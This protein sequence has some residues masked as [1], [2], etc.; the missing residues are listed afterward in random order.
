MFFYNMRLK[1]FQGTS[2]KAVL[3]PTGYSALSLSQW[4]RQ[5]NNIVKMSEWI[6]VRMESERKFVLEYT[7]K[8]TYLKPRNL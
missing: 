5:K 7:E 2:R 4:W 1:Y 3:E 8:L 6:L